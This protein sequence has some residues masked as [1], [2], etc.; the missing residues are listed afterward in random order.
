MTKIVN[1]DDEAVTVAPRTYSVPGAETRPDV[2]VR[3]MQATDVILAAL[4]AAFG[5]DKLFNGSNPLRFIRDDPK[6]SKVWV[7]DP[8]SRTDERDGN[9]MIIMVTRGE[10]QP[11]EL[12]LYN[13]AGGNFG[14]LNEYSDLAQTPLFISCEAG[15]KTGSEVLASI[16]YDVLKIFRQQ[17]MAQY[18]IHSIKLASITPAMKL[19]DVAGNPWSTVVNVRL[20]T[21][22]RVQMVELANHLNKTNIDIELEQNKKRAFVVLDSTPQ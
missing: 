6:A 21:Q 19:K 9:R 1:R 7:C 14:D 18:D 8:E 3:A 10:Y 22:E 4:Q 15:N 20:E 2:R 5:Q 12:H 11:Q 16:V 13:G 17:L